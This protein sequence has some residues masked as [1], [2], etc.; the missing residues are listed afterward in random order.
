MNKKLVAYLLGN[1]LLFV[2]PLH[3]VCA[4]IAVAT[5]DS[6]TSRTVVAFAIPFLTMIILGTVLSVAFWGHRTTVLKRRDGIGVVA[7]SWVV[8]CFF[9]AFPYYITGTTVAQ[10]IFESISG[11]TTTGA[12]IYGDI[13]SLPK[14]ILYWRSLTQW[15]GG[16]G[17]L[18]LLVAL[19]M[20]LGIRGRALVGGESSVNLSSSSTSKISDLAIH[21][22]WVYLVF[23]V[24]CFVALLTGGHLS[25]TEISVEEAIHYTLT[26]VATGGFAPHNASAAHFDSVTIECI[27]IFFM[28]LSSLS[29]VLI[30][31]M[32]FERKLKCKVGVGEAMAFFGIIVIVLT[33]VVAGL[34]LQ[35]G[36]TFGAAMRNATFPIVSMASSSG[37]GTSDYDAWP[38]AAK[39]LLAFVMIVG[40]CGGSTSGGLKV[41]RL[42]LLLR[43]LRLEIQKTFRPDIVTSIK[44]DAQKVSD[45]ILYRTLIYIVTMGFILL[46][47]C[48]IVGIM[49]PSIRD[50]ETA[51]GAVIGTLFNMGPGF[52][53]LG[54][55]DNYG[56]L[57]SHTLLFLGWL[58]LLGRLEV[59]VL[60]ALFTKALWKVN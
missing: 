27:M 34:M 53:S 57:S 41:N 20:R 39:I 26:T 54:P 48:G 31:Q 60:L 1:V 24:L 45:A 58:M 46:I 21:L 3:L 40:G 19:L 59:F 9:G 37:F 14:A 2:S 50:L 29:F 49:E 10:A 33:A 12:T 43:I 38:L 11:F 13:E 23:S 30:Y 47:S 52:G 8:V 17:I 22:L 28:L 6:W 44:V 7:L 32:I 5:D 16:L 42:T 35:S 15:I 25:G 55:T 51:V 36:M 56:A 4:L 18:V